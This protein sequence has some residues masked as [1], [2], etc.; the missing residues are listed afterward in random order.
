MTLH[1]I[2]TVYNRTIPLRMLIDCFLVQNNPNWK[3]YIVCDGPASEGVKKIIEGY[4]TE[5]RITFIQTPH[6]L[7]K[8]GHPNRKMML[9]RLSGM[10]DDY[11][12]ITNDD[13]YY[14]LVFVD[15]FL[16]SCGKDTGMVYCNTIHNGMDYGILYTR[17]KVNSI[18][19]GSFIVR[20]DVA[21]V[22][23]F[24]HMV[25]QADGIYAE[26]CARYCQD[27]RLAIK[28]IDKPLFVHN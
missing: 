23:G 12:L 28:Y 27:H 6:R 19:M 5:P 24:N 15:H 16:G 10:K 18:D 4:K 13:N 26:E 1:V 9:E 22:V 14:M 7:Q 20:L 2:C 21:K 11:V 17:I 25:L 8:W 3:L